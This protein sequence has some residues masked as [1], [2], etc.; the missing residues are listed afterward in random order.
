MVNRPE[1]DSIWIH[2][3]NPQDVHIYCGP[4]HGPLSI[5]HGPVEDLWNVDFLRFLTFL[6][7]VVHEKE[8]GVF[9]VFEVVAV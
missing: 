6:C 2:P 1:E 3:P 4:G 5:Y 8:T 9:A 7:L